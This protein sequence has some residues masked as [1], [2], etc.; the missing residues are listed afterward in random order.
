M[1][2]PDRELYREE[3]RGI[4]IEVSRHW[5][6]YP[7]ER[8]EVWCF[9]LHLALEGF[10]EEFRADL[11]QDVKH[12]DFGTPMRP[13]AECLI[14]LDWHSGMTFYEV[15]Q[16]PGYPF[17]NIKAGCDY[18]HLWD[19]DQFYSAESVMID[20]KNCVDSFLTVFPKYKTTKQLWEEYRKPFEEAQKKKEQNDARGI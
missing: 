1:L 7:R 11:F 16:N 18:N 20:A 3:H 12:S 10:P 2:K 8:S 15:T 19:E 14:G 13:Y 9:Y 17:T 5:M 6:N 4:Q